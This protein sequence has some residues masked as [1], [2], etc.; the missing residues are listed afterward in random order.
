MVCRVNI[1]NKKTGITYVYESESYWDKDKQQA[2]NKRTCIGKLDA[3]NK[4]LV[5]SKRLSSEIARDS[6]VIISTSAIGATLILDSITQQLALDKLL[7]TVFPKLHRQ[8]Q[9]VLSVSL[10]DIACEAD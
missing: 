8:I 1:F 7:K 4:T 3:E 6:S 10:C 9:S 5:P 2:R